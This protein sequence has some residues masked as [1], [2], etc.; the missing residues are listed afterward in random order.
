MKETNTQHRLLH[1]HIAPVAQGF[2]MRSKSKRP[3]S[4]WLAGRNV[5]LTLMLPQATPDGT[6]QTY[7]A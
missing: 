4:T 7:Y 6:E 2:G 3:S 5:M 1:F